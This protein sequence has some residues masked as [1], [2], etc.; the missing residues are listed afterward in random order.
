M[1]MRRIAVF[2]AANDGYVPKAVMALRSFQR[3][4]PDYGYFLLGAKA[5][6][7]RESLKFI[8]HH[9]IELLDVDEAHRFVKQGRTKNRFPV[10]TIYRLKGPELLAERGFTYSIQADG[11]VFCVRPLEIENLLGRI[12]G[13]AGVVVG[14]LGRTLGNKQREENEEFDFSLERV[15]DTLGLELDDASLRTKYEV[16]GGVLFWNNV[17][18]AKLGLFD[19][20][21]QVFRACRGCFEGSQ[22]LMTFTAA[23]HD[24]PFLE[25]GD[26][27][28]FSF[29]EDHSLRID[30]KVQRE[31]RRGK[32]QHIYIVHFLYC[33]PWL[34]PNRPDVAKAHFINA[35]RQ[36][37]VDEL[38]DKAYELFD[39][40]SVVRPVSFAY[41][42]FYVR[43]ISYWGIIR[44][45]PLRSWPRLIM[46]LW[47]ERRKSSK[48]LLQKR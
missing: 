44:G 28:N 17:F 43:A 18:M 1:M 8:R 19:R 36:F 22:D 30:E 46:K 31:V 40:L 20:V 12:E 42:F 14:D 35:W 11:D 15:R 34:R 5:A 29:F 3:W 33:K 6:M 2:A 37:V 9:N 39:D 24:I 10:E 16:N 4:Y 26:P 41:R 25:L 7:S 47:M 21:I 45:Q 38:G 48:I 27:Y 13:F 32:F 23:V